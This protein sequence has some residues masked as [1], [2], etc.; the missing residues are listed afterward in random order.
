LVTIFDP[1]VP[2]ECFPGGVALDRLGHCSGEH[3]SLSFPTHFALI[4]GCR[5]RN[6]A[7]SA[8]DAPGAVSFGRSETSKTP[9]FLFSEEFYRAG[10]ASLASFSSPAGKKN[11]V[12]QQED[13]EPELVGIPVGWDSGE[14]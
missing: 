6:K 2:K 9:L 3:S 12:S 8:R 7:W 14:Q 11:K 1:A 10:E 5:A 13:V 4:K